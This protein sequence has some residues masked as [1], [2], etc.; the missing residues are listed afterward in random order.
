MTSQVPNTRKQ[1]ISL[2]KK[3]LTRIRESVSVL[4]RS[5]SNKQKLADN[6]TVEEFEGCDEG[7]SEEVKVTQECSIIIDNGLDKLLSLINLKFHSDDDDEKVSSLIDSKNLCEQFLL[8]IL[9]ECLIFGLVI[10][11]NYA[12]RSASLELLLF[13][14]QTFPEK[15][16]ENLWFPED[17]HNLKHIVINDSYESNKEMAVGLLKQFSAVKLQFVSFKK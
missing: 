16:W 11:A 1:I 4:N 12:R 10:D 6:S 9:R 13:F 17:M 3:V 15:K 14:Q 2:Y 5:I 7:H 8:Y